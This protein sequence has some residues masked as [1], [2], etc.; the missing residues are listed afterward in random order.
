[1]ITRDGQRRVDKIYYCH[2]R[3]SAWIKEKK[4]THDDATLPVRGDYFSNLYLYF[5][6]PRL[7]LGCVRECTFSTNDETRKE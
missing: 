3:P 2:R 6:T 7:S 1:M 5:F 4:N